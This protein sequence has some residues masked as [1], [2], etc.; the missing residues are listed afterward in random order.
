MATSGRVGFWTWLWRRLVTT[1][2][3]ELR[4]EHNGRVAAQARFWAELRE[5][6][7]EAE[8]RYASSAIHGRTHER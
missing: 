2:R 1:A 5:G 8:A 4:D 3:D 7:R 6:R